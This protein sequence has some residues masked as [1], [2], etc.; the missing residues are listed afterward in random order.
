MI[1]L[2]VS[3]ASLAQLDRSESVCFIV[4]KVV[5]LTHNF[6]IQPEGILLSRNNVRVGL[7]EVLEARA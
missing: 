5:I 6:K 3:E 4:V 2:R 7:F 1:L